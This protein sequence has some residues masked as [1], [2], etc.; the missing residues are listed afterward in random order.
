MHIFLCG[1]NASNIPKELLSNFFGNAAKSDSESPWLFAF[2]S[3]GR[4]IGGIG[5]EGGVGAHKGGEG[6]IGEASKIGIENISLFSRI[7]GGTGGK[8]GFGGI[9]GGRGGTGQGST[10]S[11]LLVRVDENAR[12]AQP[13]PL[14]DFAISDGLCQLL[15]NQGFVTVG[16]I[17]EVTGDD[18]R[19]VGF[20]LGHIATLKQKLE[21]FLRK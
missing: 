6:G 18:L 13:T 20:E 17:F 5:G 19:D 3:K 21:A 16:G 9:F 1:C 8:G 15:H 10:F 2:I 11:E 14:A 12:S 4:N 7:F